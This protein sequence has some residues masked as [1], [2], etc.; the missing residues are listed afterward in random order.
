M[1]DNFHHQ[2]S[3]QNLEIIPVALIVISPW[4]SF[5]IYKLAGGV[6]T[7]S[8]EEKTNKCVELEHVS[9]NFK[10]EEDGNSEVLERLLTKNNLPM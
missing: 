9:Q 10:M 3:Y 8:L 5:L 6:V 2:N 4:C 1:F 7:Y